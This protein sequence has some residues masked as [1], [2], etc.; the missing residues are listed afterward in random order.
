MQSYMLAVGKPAPASLL[1]ISVALV[2]PVLL[3]AVLYPL[4]LTGLWLNLPIASLLTG[5]LAVGVFL[6]LRSQF[7]RQD[8]PIT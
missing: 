6:K 3:M 5:L 1:S 7:Y 4:G 2:F 8:E